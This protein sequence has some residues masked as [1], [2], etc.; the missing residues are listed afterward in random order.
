MSRTRPHALSLRFCP[1]SVRTGTTSTRYAAPKKRNTLN[2][3]RNRERPES[4]HGCRF[5]SFTLIWLGAMRPSSCCRVRRPWAPPLSPG[6]SAPSAPSTAASPT[7]LADASVMA[8][9]PSLRCTAAAP[10]DAGSP[11]LSPAADPARVSCFGAAPAGG[12]TTSMYE[13]F[14]AP[15]SLITGAF[16]FG[17]GAFCGATLDDLCSRAPGVDSFAAGATAAFGTTRP[18]PRSQTGTL[19]TPSRC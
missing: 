12:G 1:T 17:A 15:F 8:G 7:L 6:A 11:Y 5:F 4:I 3:R 16:L 14:S 18:P 13:P 10:G 19:P 9:P 2:K